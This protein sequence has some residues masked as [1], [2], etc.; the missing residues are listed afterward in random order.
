LNISV[1]INGQAVETVSFTDR[2]LH[3]GD[4]LFET[5]AIKDGRPQHW[6]RHQQRLLKGC[7]RLQ[8]PTPD[9]E[10]LTGELNL[11]A[12]GQPRAVI[13]IIITRGQGGRGYK[14]PESIVT[15]RIVARYP[16]PAYPPDYWQRGVKIR[17]CST[18]L[19]INPAL[20]GIKHCNRL[21]QILARNEWQDVDI[22]EGLMFDT[23][24]NIIEGTMTN[25]FMVKN[26]SLL[27]PSVSQCG[28]EGVMRGI[29]ME[30]ARD[31]KLGVSVDNI[32]VADIQ[33]AD[34]LF[35]TNSVVGIWPVREFESQ[36]YTKGPVT[37]QL[38]QYLSIPT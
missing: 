29:V 18:P 33:N 23:R 14:A 36:T 3:Y 6:Q 32:S 30:A 22:A 9:M 19:G 10:Q 25:L 38:M 35:L 15:T 34:E 26:N 5:I 16:F 31:Q 37:Q 17:L 28:V 27:T 7:Q 11:L 8:F 24:Q 13:K 4:G 2:G 20:A 1:L 21:E 12:S